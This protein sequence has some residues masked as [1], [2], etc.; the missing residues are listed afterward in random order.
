MASGR[1]PTPLA[2][3]AGWSQAMI[4]SRPSAGTSGALARASAARLIAPGSVARISVRRLRSSGQRIVRHCV[5]TSFSRVHTSSVVG[6]AVEHSRRVA[7]RA[8]APLANRRIFSRSQPSSRPWQKAPPKLSPAPEA[9]DRGDRGRRHLDDLVPGHAQHALRSLLDDGDLHA[10]VQQRLRGPAGLGLAD[11]DLAFLLVADRHG[12]VRQRGPDLLAGLRPCRPRT[13][14]GSPDPGW[15]GSCGPG[16]ARPRGART[17][18]ARPTT[19]SRSTS[20]SRRRRWPPG[21]VPRA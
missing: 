9:V 2:P 4:I 7:T 17:G 3:R 5:S 20:R 12:D 15:C 1:S 11:R 10:G 14:R 19:R 21:P 16:P 6:I 8:P 13:P 18:S